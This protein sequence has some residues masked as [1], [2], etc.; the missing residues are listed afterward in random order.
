LIQLSVMMAI[1]AGRPMMAQHDPPF[2]PADEG[3]LN[4]RMAAGGH[5]SER[6]YGHRAGQD[7]SD[8]AARRKPAA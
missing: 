8:E 5:D 4:D 2:R 3:K 6:G 1:G 7:R